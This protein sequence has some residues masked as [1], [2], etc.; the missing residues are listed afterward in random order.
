MHESKASRDDLF[1]VST[2]TAEMHW[3]T[4]S[5]T[6]GPPDHPRRLL[7]RPMDLRTALPLRLRHTRRRCRRVRP[8]DDRPGTVPRARRIRHARRRRQ[9]LPSDRSLCRLSSRDV[10][11]AQ[12]YDWV[13]AV[14]VPMARAARVRG[15]RARAVSRRRRR[16]R[17]HRHDPDEHLRRK[18]RR[19]P[20]ARSGT[21]SGKRR[22]RR[23]GE[24]APR[25]IGDVDHSL[26]L[27]GI[28]E[29][30]AL[31]VMSPEPTPSEG[32]AHGR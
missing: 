14:R 10:Q 6:G 13:L 31:I 7:R 24:R 26:A 25:H 3:T 29:R 19:G 1:A 32:E 11:V 9:S 28:P 22:S 5:R 27:V 15:A 4:S 16:P 8:D 12:L 18:P 20:A 23:W 30:A 21:M 17:A 2:S